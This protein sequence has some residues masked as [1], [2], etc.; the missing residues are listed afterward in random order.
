MCLRKRLPRK[1]MICQSREKVQG[2]VFFLCRYLTHLDND[3]L[4]VFWHRNPSKLKIF[5]EVLQKKSPLQLWKVYGTFST[6]NY[7]GR[8]KL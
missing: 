7:G 8:F 6:E 4:Q 3:I 5:P 2:I 1:Q